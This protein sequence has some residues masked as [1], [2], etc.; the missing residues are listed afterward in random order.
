MNEFS[1]PG[2]KKKPVLFVGNFLSTSLGNRSV[3]EDLSIQ[4][5]NSGHEVITTSNKINRVARLIDMIVTVLTKRKMY[6][7]AHVDVFSG[8][9]FL[10][11]EA[12]CEALK[13][14][15]K[16]YILTLH[17]GNLPAFALRWPKRVRRLLFSAYAVT[18]PSRYLYETMR[19]YRT[20][21][22]LIPNPFTLKC[23][24]FQLRQ[25]TKPSLLWLR[26]FHSMYNP[27]LAPKVIDNLRGA[28]PSIHL[29]MIGPDRGDGS[30][31][32]TRETVR[33]LGI[34]DHVELIGS[35][36][37]SDVP[38]WLNKADIFL[39]TTNID[40]TPVSVIEAMASGLCIVS[41]KVGGIP[42]LLNH[43]HDALLV[44]PDDPESMAAAVR[45][46]L[47]DPGL[48]EHLSQNARRKAE[49]FDWSQILPRWEN[50]LTLLDERILE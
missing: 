47:S 39:N 42:Y 36:A 26:S 25:K 17:G 21:L 9:A 32:A 31:Q 50:V 5:E 30:I 16:P 27:S 15:G 40:N 8:L 13:W 48:A 19:C 6:A 12:V 1:N 11:A 45:R 20:E 18:T 41:T 35:I 3:C 10:W 4:L 38:G 2:H 22:E 28:F 14:L 37:K 44:P 43:E 46:I 24:T 49:Q 29:L 33:R 34:G 23:Y 7:V